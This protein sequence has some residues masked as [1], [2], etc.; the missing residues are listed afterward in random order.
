MTKNNSDETKIAVIN[1]NIEFIKKDILEIKFSLNDQYATRE[2]LVTVV[3]ETEL[4]L[5]RL[6]NSSNMWKFLSPTLAAVMGSVTT[7]LLIQ[8]LMG[9]R[10]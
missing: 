5:Q 9:I 7:F 6:E 10:V 8:Y 3:K 1:A 4:R 2:S